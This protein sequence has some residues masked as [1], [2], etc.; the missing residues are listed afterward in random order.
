MVAEK[1][2][3]VVS[4][5]AAAAV[6]GDILALRAVREDEQDV[7]AVGDDAR[8]NGDRAPLCRQR[9]GGRNAVI[10]AAAARTRTIGIK[11]YSPRNTSSQAAGSLAGISHAGS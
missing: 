2:V 1:H 5:H 3:D 10:L 9:A 8:V 4:V 11:V 7:R 6:L